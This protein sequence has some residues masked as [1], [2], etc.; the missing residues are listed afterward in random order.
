[1]ND[2]CLKILNE[3]KCNVTLLFVYDNI[4]KMLLIKKT[5]VNKVLQMNTESVQ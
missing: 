4:I 3:V 2:C 5:L 1:M